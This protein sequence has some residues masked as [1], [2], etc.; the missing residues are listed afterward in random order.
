HQGAEDA[1]RRHQ[2]G[3][4][5]G[6][7]GGDVARC[8]VR[9]RIEVGQPGGGLDQVVV[10]GPAGPG[11]AGAEAH[12][13]AVDDA[14]RGRGDVG[15]PQPEALDRGRPDVVHEHVAVG[16]EAEQRLAL[17]GPLEVA[18]HATLAPDDVEVHDAHTLRA[19]R[20]QPH[21]TGATGTSHYHEP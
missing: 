18:H 9:P 12:G 16:G 20:A 6:D 4:L 10:G 14:G 19:Y 7:D 8:A 3:R 15:V 2:P 13:G 11:A 21:T 5:V 1:D 17:L